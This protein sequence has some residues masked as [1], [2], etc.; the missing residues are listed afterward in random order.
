M[1][2]NE[3]SCAL[4]ASCT[5]QLITIIVFIENI[6]EVELVM[7]NMCCVED[8][9]KAGLKLALGTLIKQCCAILIDQYATSGQRSVADQIREFT[10]V[11][12]SPTHSA[13]LMAT[14]EYQL[15]E[16]R[17]RQN[18]KPSHFPD[19][20]ELAK[21]MAFVDEELTSTTDITSTG[22]FVQARKVEL[23]HVTLL[24]A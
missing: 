24:K 14:A 11:F 23:A 19:E 17:Q 22:A 3:T 13:K 12:S 18:R 8:N 6:R 20:A 21:L 7:N 5:C 4:E 15:K 10:D 2:G 16:K 1:E 9:L